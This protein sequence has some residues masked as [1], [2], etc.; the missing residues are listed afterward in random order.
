MSK[1]KYMVMSQRVKEDISI[2]QFINELLLDKVIREINMQRDNK[3]SLTLVKNP[4][5]QN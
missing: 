1:A 4:K 2:Q 5:S 3:T